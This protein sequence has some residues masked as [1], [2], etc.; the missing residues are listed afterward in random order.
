ML[1]GQVIAGGDESVTVKVVVQVAALFAASLTVTVIVV[2]PSPTGVPAAGFC[3]IASEP[4]GVQL[5]EAVTPPTTF[6]TAAWQF[7][8]AEAVVPAG[9]VADGGLVSFTVTTAVHELDPP[10]LSVT[11]SVTVV[12]PSEYGAAG[13]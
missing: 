3:V 7:A 2:T 5:S 1:P 12:L 10:L 13:V 6:G 8:S 4:A 11:V 9:Q